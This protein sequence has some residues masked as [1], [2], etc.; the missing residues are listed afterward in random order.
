MLGQTHLIIGIWV[1]IILHQLKYGSETFNE[2]NILK[3]KR[4]LIIIAG[5]GGFGPDFDVV[6]GFIASLITYRGVDIDYILLFHGVP[7]HTI[8][9]FGGM[10]LIY[11]FLRH[12]DSK[13]DKY[14]GFFLVGWSTHLLADWF[15]NCIDGFEPF[16]EG[17][18]GL[19]MVDKLPP[20]LRVEILGGYTQFAIWDII[21][22]LTIIFLI[23]YGLKLDKQ[24]R[25]VKKSD[26]DF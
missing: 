5:I 22:L 2:L 19:H 17:K 20:S 3:E 13:Y 8:Y 15:D 4:N 9:F 14:I 10:I 7:S 21:I 6:V 18:W 1:G 26:Q 23:Y 12:T 16:I 25:N 24:I 11:F